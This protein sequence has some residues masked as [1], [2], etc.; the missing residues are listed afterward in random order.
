MR[1][2]VAREWEVWAAANLLRGVEPRVVEQRLVAEGV[3]PEMAGALLASMSAAPLFEAAATLQADARRFR[4]LS[5]A[6]DRQLRSAVHP[7]SVV[8]ED[9]CTPER[10]H[11]VFVAAGMPVRLCGL[12][13]RAF[14]LEGWAP[15]ALAERFGAM[16]IEL[17]IDRQDDE[18]YSRTFRRRAGTMPLTRLV[19]LFEESRQGEVY[20]VAENRALER[21]RLREIRREVHF[22]E[23]WVRAAQLQRPGGMALWLG[24]AGTTTTL[25]RDSYDILFCQLHGAKRWRLIPPTDAALLARVSAPYTTLAPEEVEGA[26]VKEVLVEAGQ[27][28]FVPAGWWHHVHALEPSCSISV[29][30]LEGNDLPDRG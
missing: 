29:M 27:A 24:P 26:L 15:R 14:D 30:A 21:T 7:E 28:L 25:H 8:T 3:S 10:F 9:E 6:R 13:G 11:D 2:R 16:E 1:Q 5:T 19:A 23:G 22:P 17:T 18:D 20:V 12:V 4:A